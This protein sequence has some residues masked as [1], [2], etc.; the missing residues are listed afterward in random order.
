[1]NRKL[2][3][4]IVDDHPGMCCTLKDILESEDHK[5]VTVT[6]GLAA[7][8]ICKEQRFDVILMDIRMPDLN[9]VETYLRIKE[10]IHGT[11]VIL[12]SAFSV[13]EL[14]QEALE[15]GAIAFL[16]K[17]LDIEQTLQLIRQVE[18]PPAL[19]VMEDK[20]ELEKQT[21]KLNEQNYRVYTTNTAEEA[22]SLA[23]QIRFN[24]I[25]I[26]GRLHRMSSLEMY[27]ALK[28][29]TP[30]SVTIMLS[31]D[32]KN[33]LQHANEAVR[34]NAY[35]FLEKP[36]EPDK[37]LSILE[38]HKRQQISD[39]LEKLGATCEKNTRW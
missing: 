14:K 30:T 20:K 17:P 29:V 15:A 2:S 32:D 12:M 25:M 16:Q 11:R 37:L 34:K 9:G 8:K 18:Y 10:Y 13:D 27:L 26:D 19:V 4:L 1:M 35:T 31:E 33:F 7:V 5:V 23:S 36:L 28:K 6:S 21:A 3:V 38:N 22:L 24:L 39:L